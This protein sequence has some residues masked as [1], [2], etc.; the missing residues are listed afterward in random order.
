M[1][2]HRSGCAVFCASLTILIGSIAE[3]SHA[4]L[5]QLPPFYQNVW[6]AAAPQSPTA[7]S[8]A[9]VRQAYFQAP[10][11]TP[12]PPL[13]PP[14]MNDASYISPAAFNQF[15]NPG[16]AMPATQVQQLP[17]TQLRDANSGANAESQPRIRT[18]AGVGLSQH[19]DA[20]AGLST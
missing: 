6:K 18:T 1:R 10:G 5:T 3:Q 11:E 17:P 8:S 9:A 16:G 20:T 13:S 15:S 7:A 4:Q 14:G 2:S 19:G 12:M